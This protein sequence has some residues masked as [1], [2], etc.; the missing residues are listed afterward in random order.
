MKLRPSIRVRQLKQRKRKSPTAEDGAQGPE[1][2]CNNR[3]EQLSQLQNDDNDD[4]I[5]TDIRN[6]TQLKEKPSGLRDPKP[7]L[8]FVYGVAN[9]KDMVAHL[10][11][12][13]EEDQYYCKLQ[14]NYKEIQ[15]APNINTF[16]DIELSPSQVVPKGE[17]ITTI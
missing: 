5:L 1:I 4:V 3:Y 7:P 9:F 14:S 8:I 17:E 16:V 2:N 12:T 15:T 11:P 10:T 13:I 6:N